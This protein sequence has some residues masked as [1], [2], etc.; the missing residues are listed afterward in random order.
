MSTQGAV[1]LMLN[2]LSRE[3]ISALHASALV[4]RSADAL[5][6]LRFAQMVNGE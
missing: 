2:K 1:L 5:R 6:V 4:L 3:E